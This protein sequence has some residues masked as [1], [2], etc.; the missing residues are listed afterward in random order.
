MPVRGVPRQDQGESTELGGGS[1]RGFVGWR[2]KEFGVYGVVW[3]I[4]KMMSWADQ[5]LEDADKG[6]KCR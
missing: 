2:G 5:G 4:L 6:A 3:G 1:A